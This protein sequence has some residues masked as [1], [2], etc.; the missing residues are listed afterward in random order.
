MTSTKATLRNSVESLS[1]VDTV[2][3]DDTNSDYDD[4]RMSAMVV[5]SDDQI[6]VQ[7][8]LEYE[9]RFINL[10]QY[11]KISYAICDSGADF[12]IG[13]KR[14]KVESVTMKTV[15]SVGYGLL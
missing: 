7:A 13:G 14:A 2:S 10:V 4:T 6:E 11:P 8:N 12:C 5:S 3:D 1:M 15:N 9:K